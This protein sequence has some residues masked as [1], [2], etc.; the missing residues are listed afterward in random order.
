MNKLQK[1]LC[2]LLSLL[3]LASA[4]L[5]A[6]A[7]GE[8]PAEADEAAVAEGQ[9]EVTFPEELIVGHPTVTKGDFFTELFGND[10]ADIDVR[11]LIHGYN[12]VNWDQ[13]QGTYVIDPSVVKEYRVEVD[14][15][16][17]KIFELLL[18]DD[19]MYSD[20]SPITAWDYAFSILLMMSPE[21]EAIGGKIYRAQHLLGYD[22]YIKTRKKI[23]NG[24]Q[25]IFGDGED[26]D[27]FS[28]G[29]VEVHSDH[30]I[31]ITLDH[32]FLPY[33]FETGLLMTVPYP[34]DVIAPGCKVYME[35][36]G[37][38]YIGNADNEGKEA[39]NNLSFTNP[40][41]TPELLQTTILDPETGYNSH[42]SKVSGPYTMVSWDAETG[43][44]HYEINP[45]FKGAWMQN[46]LPGPDYSG[47]VHYIQVMGDDGEPMLTA[48]G[49][50]LWLVK[51]TIEK[52]KFVVADNETL[53]QQLID[54]DL[55]L[56]NKVTYGPT[57]KEGLD[58][59]VA[60]QQYPRIG[61]AFLTFTYDWPTVHEKEVR[62]AIAWCMDRDLM[63]SHYC[64]YANENT[65]AINSLGTRVDGYFGIEQWE[66]KL[67]NGQLGGFPV[68]IVEQFI[69]VSDDPEEEKANKEKREELV[70]KYKYFYVHEEDYEKAVAAWE[71]LTDGW[72]TG[73]TDYTVDLKK[74]EHLLESNGWTLNKDG[75]PYQK[76]VDEYRCKKMEDGT[77][78]ELNLTMMYPEGNRMAD[79]MQ[80]DVR[81]ESDP[82]PYP[83]LRDDKQP[84]PD[85][86]TFVGNLAAVGIKLTLVPEKME[87]LLKSY[88]RQTERTTDM[89]Y[90]ATNFHVIVDPSIT[91]STDDTLNHEI[92]NNTYSDD[93]D[94]FYRA[95]SMRETEPGDIFSYVGKW[96]SFQERYNEVLPTIPVYSNIYFDFLNENLQNYY[97]TGQVT[98]SQAILPAYFALED[99]DAASRQA[100]LEDTEEAGDED[101]E[102]FE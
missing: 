33:F 23:L 9:E 12:L 79:I 15:D 93:E 69:P 55:H 53:I 19:L 36:G 56:V 67:V 41:F 85:A 99:Y 95:K 62:Q 7:E 75:E 84:D 20:G 2:L 34:I 78:V 68:N 86:T 46:N 43:D 100:A 14:E 64:G 45:Y 30:E 25:L 97:I 40:V 27:T 57:I 21:V 87:D 94:L 80:N 76:G 66:Y 58:K 96:I 91:Y 65:G 73:I 81:T 16:G 6:L 82:A 74:A 101:F 10:T 49:D 28:L 77:L 31:W 29:G 8:E 32:E 18:W 60:R 42:P 98:W 59:G 38:I 61:L 11:A 35:E 26:A 83:A 47:P 5:T 4:P 72:N 70:N 89:I 37:G 63:T 52:I 51:P 1:L 92:W 102:D 3:L 54:G 48:T 71:V 22:E 88:Y 44:G 24:E 39:D 50:E 17:N 90:L 13:N